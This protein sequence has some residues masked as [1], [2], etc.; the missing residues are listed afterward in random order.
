MNPPLT[1]ADPEPDPREGSAP[2]EDPASDSLPT[3]QPFAIFPVVTEAEAPGGR[4]GG[5]F[6]AILAASLPSATLAS[7]GTTVVVLRQTAPAANSRPAAVTTASTASA[8]A[9]TVSAADLTGIVAT[10][11]ASVVTI[12]ANGISTRGFSPFGETI[13]GIGSGI[14]ITTSGY[15]LTNRHVVDGSSTLSVQL[16]NGHDYPATIIKVATDND[17]A[18]IRIDA[19][20]LTAASIGSSADT[21]VGQIAVAIGSPLGTYTETVTQGIVSA[22]GRDVTVTDQVTRRQTTLRN[23]IQ[24]DAAINP[25]NS[26]GPLLNAAGAVIGINTAVSTNAEGLGFAI[27]IDA[28]KDLISLAT[29]AGA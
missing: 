22:L 26:G 27:P 7:V 18:L 11:R 23:L 25:G 10:A 1:F 28:A 5:R 17:L 14:V 15:I 9:T 13:E 21:Q 29:S 16:F 3:T 2:T 20:G 4:S 12:T 8:T 24:T 6:L 19:P